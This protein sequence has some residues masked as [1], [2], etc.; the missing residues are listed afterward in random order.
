MKR[1]QKDGL[2]MFDL[3]VSKLGV[4]GRPFT[5]RGT[6]GSD[7]L[8]DELLG[9]VGRATFSPAV[10]DHKVCNS[11][12]FGT[13]VF[14]IVDGK[15]R[16][17]IYLNQEENELMKQSDFIAPQMVWEQGQKYKIDWPPQAGSRDGTVA[18]ALDIDANGRVQGSKV[19]YESPEG[20]GFASEVMRHMRHARFVPAFRNGQPVAARFT[21]PFFF[22][23]GIGWRWKT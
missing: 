2:V 17:R 13:I 8:G 23:A 4:P 3:G 5:Y 16:V 20:F 1:G 6:P 21:M 14:A 9:Q 15:P 10:L 18:V 11:L 19:S 22:R 7:R 12:V